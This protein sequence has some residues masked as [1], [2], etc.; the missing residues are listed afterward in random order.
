MVAK[1]A[2][3]MGN[4]MKLH[5]YSYSSYVENANVPSTIIS[6]DKHKET[7]IKI[8]LSNTFKLELL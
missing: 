1:L 2:I 7:N 3:M 5:D 4:T 8:F 6:H